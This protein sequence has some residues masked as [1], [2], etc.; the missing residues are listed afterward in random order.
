MSLDTF[1]NSLGDYPL[2]KVGE[3]QP[4]KPYNALEHL[5]YSIYLD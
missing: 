1:L 4:Y 3:G 5:V 2:D